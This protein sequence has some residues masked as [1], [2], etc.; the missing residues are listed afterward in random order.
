MRMD[1]VFGVKTD[2][3]EI[4][5]AWVEQATGVTGEGRESA[6]LGGDYYLFKHEE[7]KLRLISN[8]DFEDYEP[9]YTESDEWP[10]AMR[11]E[12]AKTDSPLL[13]GLESAADHFVKLQEETY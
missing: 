13:R 3:M 11:L 10:L 8:R 5:R 1:V 9:I 4:A 6:A 2:D 12:D 7:A